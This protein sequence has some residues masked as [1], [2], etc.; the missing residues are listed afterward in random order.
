LTEKF[1]TLIIALSGLGAT[2]A[3]CSTNEDKQ[4]INR[5]IRELKAAGAEE[6][7]FHFNQLPLLRIS[8]RKNQEPS[9]SAS[10]FA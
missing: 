8:Q 3:R 1:A 7:T 4:D 2:Y 10:T 5:Q 9:T 6:V